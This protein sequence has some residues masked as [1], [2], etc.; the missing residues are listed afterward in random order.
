LLTN[1]KEIK[2]SLP[3]I[4]KLVVLNILHWL[5][6]ISFRN[7]NIWVFGSWDGK[8]FLD[9]SKYLFLA[10]QKLSPNIRSV[11]I[12]NNAAIVESLHAQ[13][14]R[15]YCTWQIRA[16]LYGLM[17]KYYFIDHAPLY[18][19][20]F[21]PTNLW[22]SG[23]AKIIQLWHGL[24]LKRLDSL[25]LKTTNSSKITNIFS[26]LSKLSLFNLFVNYYVISTSRLFGRLMGES[27]EVPQERILFSGYPRNI[28]YEAPANMNFSLQK[29]MNDKV[30]ALK[31]EGKKLV[32]Y[33]PTFRDYGG[34]PVNDKA[35]DLG[36]LEKFGGDNSCVFIVKFHEAAENKLA[37]NR[38]DLIFLPSGYDV[39][40]I[41]QLCDVLITDY[42]SIFFDF[43]SFNRPV[44]FYPYDLL[45]YQ[46]SARRF[47]FNYTQFV[48]GQIV[49]RF[50]ELLKLLSEILVT[51][52]DGYREKREKLL[53]T[54][55]EY[56][57]LMLSNIL[58]DY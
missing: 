26:S 5:S 6:F 24:P 48:P 3:N 38:K 23:G 54:S 45:E 29:A 53:E 2:L 47:Y 31:A 16:I 32:F 42:S 8:S 43:L 4:V 56:K 20:L 50:D 44:V 15:A 46:T 22:L 11:W 18:G 27:F 36:A 12:S 58:V 7:K 1:S 57:T 19:G 34:N 49:Y 14:Y 13:G 41:L 39:Y 25:G 21:A 33:I 55:F 28:F 52:T 9:N 30:R 37:A 51:G 17:A 35:I 10:S 40:E